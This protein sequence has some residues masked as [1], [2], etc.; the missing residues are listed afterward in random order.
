MQGKEMKL[1]KK[2]INSLSHDRRFLGRN[3]NTRTP[4]YEAMF[5]SIAERSLVPS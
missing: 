3:L 4:V 5:L 1:L 2:P